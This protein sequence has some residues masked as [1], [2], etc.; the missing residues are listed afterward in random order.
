MPESWWLK[1]ERAEKHFQELQGEIDRY[2]AT[3]PFEAVRLTG[4]PKCKEH[5]DCWRYGPRVTNQP[6]PSIAIVAGDVLHNA[7]SALDHLAVALV[8]RSRRR[9][10]SF[11]IELE[12]IWAQRGHWWW[13]HYVVR[14][15]GRRQRFASA[16]DGMSSGAIAIIRKVQPYNR[17]DKA[18]EHV[19][20]LLSKL[21]NA[22]KHRELVPFAA[23]LNNTVA[24][25]KARGHEIDLHMPDLPDGPTFVANGAL[26]AHFAYRT[27]PGEAA[28]QER[29]I[30]VTVRGTPLVAIQLTDRDSKEDLP[31][32]MPLLDLLE[33]L[34]R[35]IKRDIFPALEPHVP[36]PG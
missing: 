6:G 27:W 25:V 23:G 35:Q 32:Y 21:E 15:Q 22:D 34:L 29:E 28:L 17:G 10:A 13:R 5:R 16:I 26:V 19:L 9:S 33:T 36:P 12:D 18:P 3:H 7:R 8:P 1:V 14:D 24:A 2:T 4:R 30:Y 11:P 31:A 20:Y